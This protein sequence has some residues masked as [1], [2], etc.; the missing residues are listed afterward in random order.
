MNYPFHTSG[1]GVGGLSCALALSKYP[2]IEV[3]VYEAAAKF[4][5]LGAGIGVWPRELRL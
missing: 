5:E 4:G 2:D 3:V 1:A